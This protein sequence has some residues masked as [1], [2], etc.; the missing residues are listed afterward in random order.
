M[1]FVSILLTH[2]YVMPLGLLVIFAIFMWFNGRREAIYLMRSD[3]TTFKLGTQDHHISAFLNQCSPKKNILFY[4]PGRGIE[5]L[6]SKLVIIPALEKEYGVEVWMFL[7]PSSPGI[8]FLGYPKA[9]AQAASAHLKEAFRFIEHYSERKTTCNLFVHS[10]GNLVFQYFIERYQAGSFPADLFNNVILNAAD[11]DEENSAWIDA[12][13]FCERVYIT[14]DQRDFV[15]KLSSLGPNNGKKRLGQT[16]L[17][18]GNGKVRSIDCSG[19][20]CFGSRHEYYRWPYTSRNPQLKQVFYCLFNVA[21]I[22]DGC[23]LTPRR[24]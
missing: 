19:S 23:D 1:D 14:H 10:M 6:K 20:T 12:I 13:D 24:K 2:W 17:P 16:G 7:W 9:K 21:Y 22:P 5:P 15:L 3:G 11:T 8:T 18:A 4:I